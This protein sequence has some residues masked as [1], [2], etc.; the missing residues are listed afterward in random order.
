[1]VLPVDG[2]QFLFAEPVLARCPVVDGHAVRFHGRVPGGPEVDVQDGCPGGD[3]ALFRKILHRL[4]HRRLA[5]V[6]K[7]LVGVR[8]KVTRVV[9]EE[10][11][12]K[13]K[14]LAAP[15]MRPRELLMLALCIHLVDHYLAGQVSG[16]DHFL[17][18]F[19]AVTER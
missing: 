17:E 16:A 14:R 10:R 3:A 5:A 12:L 19:K 1:V 9:F 2:L 8:L 4:G 11:C 13:V 18:D 15:G 6:L 7:Q